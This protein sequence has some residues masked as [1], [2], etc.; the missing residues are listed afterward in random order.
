LAEARRDGVLGAIEP[1]GEAEI[2][3]MAA[4]LTENLQA[5]Q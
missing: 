4:P 3:N 1:C 2:A 5:G